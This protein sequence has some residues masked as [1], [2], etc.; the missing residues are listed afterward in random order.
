MS[1]VIAVLAGPTTAVLMIPTQ[2]DWLG[3]GAIWWLNGTDPELWPT[4]IGSGFF[5][6][7]NCSTDQQRFADPVCPSAGYEPLHQHYSTWWE[8]ESG[9]FQFEILDSNLRKT[10][11][12][13]PGVCIG[14][15]T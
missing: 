9:P 3:G 5:E 15:N 8:M 12:A 14:C 4:D 10:I 1:G 2:K 6:D 7:Y 11:Y 13:R